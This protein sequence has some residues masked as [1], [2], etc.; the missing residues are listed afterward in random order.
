M[1]ASSDVCEAIASISLTTAP[2]RVGGRGKAANSAIGP[3]QIGDGPFGGVLGGGGFAGAIA[4]IS[5]S[6]WRAAS[7]TAATSRLAVG[8]GI[9]RLRGAAAHVLVALA[10][11]GGGDLDFF[12]GRLEHAGRARRPCCESAW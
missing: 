5:A 4:T 7:A 2:I 9:D 10:E 8:T 12:G 3:R 6:S 1:S 11:I